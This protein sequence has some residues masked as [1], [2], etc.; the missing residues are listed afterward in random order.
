MTILDLKLVL[1][2]EYQNIKTFFQKAMFEAGLKNFLPLQKLK[3]LFHGH[4]L[5]VI[6]MVKKL[7]ERFRKMNCKNQFKKSLE[8]KK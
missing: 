6:L 1:L 2:L 4:M 5:L 7:L 3:A 8:L